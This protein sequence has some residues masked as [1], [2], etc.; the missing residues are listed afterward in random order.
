MEETVNKV[1]AIQDES[2]AR[3]L[4]N[5]KAAARSRRSSALASFETPGSR[6]EMV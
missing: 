6:E 4:R 3:L 5:A 2:R 1:L